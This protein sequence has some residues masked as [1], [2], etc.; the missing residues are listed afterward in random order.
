MGRVVFV[1]K[2]SCATSVP[3]NV[4]PLS[5]S[6]HKNSDGNLST[7]LSSLRVSYP[8]VDRSPLRHPSSR[9]DQDFK[10]YTKLKNCSHSYVFF[11][12]SL[13]L[14]SS[15]F[16]F[17]FLLL[18][19]SFVVAIVLSMFL[20]NKIYPT[21]KSSTNQPH[22]THC[23][24][25]CLK[26]CRPITIIIHVHT[27]HFK[28]PP[29][30][31]FASG[32]RR[33]CVFFPPLVVVGQPNKPFIL[34]IQTCFAANAP[35]ASRFSFSFMQCHLSI[36]LFVCHSARRPV[37]HTHTFPK[38]SIVDMAFFLS[39]LLLFFFFACFMYILI[40][41][42]FFF[43]FVFLFYTTVKRNF[44]LGYEILLFPCSVG[45]FFLSVSQLALVGPCVES[46]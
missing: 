12:L 4:D 7:F 9:Q 22:S 5:P 26:F 27:P 35:G 28:Y 13:F 41:T 36:Y 2:L 29:P 23:F 37:F 1:F 19:F 17:P 25:F 8:L 46:F 44:K 42:P 31:Q 14:S 18:V 43:F 38:I 30:L 33:L 15:L 11:T 24:D 39:C 6:A 40:F 16:S 10:I 45:P 3:G 32:F 20:P 21:P 34:P